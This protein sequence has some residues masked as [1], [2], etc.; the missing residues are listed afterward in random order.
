MSIRVDT[1]GHYRVTFP[2]GD[3]FGVAAAPEE[4]IQVTHGGFLNTLDAM[5]AYTI[6]VRVQDEQGHPMTGI[7][8]IITPEQ[9]NDTDLERARTLATVVPKDKAKARALAEFAVSR[10]GRTDKEGRAAI[11][12]MSNRPWKVLEIRKGRK[13][14]KIK[15]APTLM[16]GG[17]IRLVVGE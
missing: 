6:N 16:P 14:L 5:G 2:D 12:I 9:L 17:E 11:T 10:S 3:K 1:P 4:I 7:K 8:V 13:S 15:E